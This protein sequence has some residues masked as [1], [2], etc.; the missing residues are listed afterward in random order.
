MDYNSPV[1]VSADQIEFVAF[2]RNGR[3]PLDAVAA[4]PPPL[5]VAVQAYWTQVTM[6]MR[7]LNEL[8]A[9]ALNLTR[10][11]FEPFYRHDPNLVL[12]LSHYP[13]PPLEERK[14]LRYGAHTDFQF[15]TILMQDP[16]YTS[17]EGGLEVL[18][19]SGE[20][21]CCPLIPNS[22]VVNVGDLLQ[23]WSN[24]R[25][26]SNVHRVAPCGAEVARSRLSTVFFTGPSDDTIVSPLPTCI[27]KGEKG[28]YESIVSGVHLQQKLA[29][30]SLKKL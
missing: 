3:E 25:W 11:Y 12:K 16:E 2:K 8:C 14:E 29:A 22:F 10:D 7:K 20:W 13:I 26:R 18:M 9:Q 30:I 27:S 1:E 4:L 24:D 28:K 17:S 5:V 15:L 6:L 21:A 23:L 19:P